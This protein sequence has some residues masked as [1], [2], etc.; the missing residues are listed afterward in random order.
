MKKIFNWQVFL[1]LGLI[2]LS[3]I[4]YYV[5]YLM[6]HDVH[7]IF[8]YLMGDIAFVFIEVLMVA[9]I[10]HKLLEHREKKVMLKKLNMVIGVFFTEV[11]TELLE[12]LSEMDVGVAKIKEQ[13]VVTGRWTARDFANI[14]KALGQYKGEIEYDGVGLLKIRDFL[15]SKRDF[16]LNLLENPN[17][18][19]H[20]SFTDLL[21]AV[22]HL[23][24]ELAYREDLDDL[25]EAD[26]A[27]ICGDI[28]RAYGHL[29]FEWLDY[30]M[31]LKSDYPYLFSLAMR[32]NPFDAEACVEVK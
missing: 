11:G 20:E 9:L 3:A 7:H 10:L 6:F 13:L 24:E 28:Q 31:H 32:T 4:V 27:H 2:L 19:E 5:H 21:W 8:I 29:I 15:R 17:L 26:A 22:F 16:L 1:G 23:A 12:L 30:M 25:P 14:K 18:L